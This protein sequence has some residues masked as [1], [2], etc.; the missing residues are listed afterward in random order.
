MKRGVACADSIP[1]EAPT[2]VAPEAPTAVAPEAPTAVAPEA[3]T[4]VAPEAPWTHT[5]PTVV[6]LSLAF[7]LARKGTATPLAAGNKSNSRGY[8]GERV[9]SGAV[10]ERGTGTEVRF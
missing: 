2:A 1:P 7:G 4:A 9:M 5:A 3:P 10:V 8:K 6:E